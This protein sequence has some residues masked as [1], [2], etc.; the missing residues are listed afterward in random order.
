MSKRN[1]ITHKGVRCFTWQACVHYSYQ[2]T[3]RTETNLA[4]VL[5]A[6]SQGIQVIKTP[7]YYCTHVHPIVSP[8]IRKR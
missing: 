5:I 7:G 6:M 4:Q 3:Q 2:C 1:G 8:K